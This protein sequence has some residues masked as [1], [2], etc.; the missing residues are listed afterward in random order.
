M[1]LIF[2]TLPVSVTTYAFLLLNATAVERSGYRRSDS[3][4]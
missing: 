4:A 1:P 3:R 2:R